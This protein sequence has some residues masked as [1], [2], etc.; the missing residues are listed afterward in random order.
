MYFPNGTLINNWFEEDEL[1][2]R[3]GETR[4]VTATHTE[5]PFPKRTFDPEVSYTSSQ[6]RDDTYK[7]VIGEKEPDGSFKTTNQ[8]YGNHKHPE[9][10]Y[11]HKKLSQDEHDE[12]FRTFY[13]TQTNFKNSILKAK[14]DFRSFD[15]S[16]KSF[17]VA[18]PQESY[19]G[20]R[21]MF[22]QDYFPVP[23]EKAVT[24]I[25]IE[26]LKKM[27][28]GAPPEKKEIKKGITKFNA[29]A[30]NIMRNN[31]DSNFWLNNINSGNIY[32]S[33]LKKPNP[34]ARSSGF[35]QLLK[36]TKGAV[37]YYQNVKNEDFNFEPSEEEK[38][39][40]EEERKKKEEEEKRLKEE[41]EENLKKISTIPDMKN[42]ILGYVTDENLI[43]LSNKIPKEIKDKI[44]K[45]MMQRGWVGLRL[46]KIF[47]R[48]LSKNKSEII[49]RN[50]FKYYLN[51]QA[52]VLTDDEVSKIFEI[53]DFK[54]KDFINFIIVLNCFRRVSENR[55]DLIQKFYNQL[56]TENLDFISFTKLTKMV[57]MNYHPEATKFIKVA[58]E[59]L[60]EYLISWDNF[61]E[62]DR[63]TEDQFKQYW[64]DISTCVDDDDD[65]I[66]ILRSVGYKD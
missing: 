16:T 33:F 13:K 30:N 64:F 25:P 52:I 2:R 59:I 40:M 39:I 36:D 14:N 55:K 37:Q 8:T 31:S 4:S 61:K 3:T 29:N 53:F 26:K 27:N 17:H 45:G 19:V 60:K 9:S 44:I 28:G 12:L 63:V 35:T 49:G 5:G 1:R 43:K 46:L 34:F 51:S 65:F 11:M 23:Y 21:H 58:P 41:M 15:T 56:K 57:D 48:G 20:L 38:K 54:R 42:L 24:L 10:K 50:D 62:D 7:R 66:Q 6:P 47:L 32:R 22:T 18:Q